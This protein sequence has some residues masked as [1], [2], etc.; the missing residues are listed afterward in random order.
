MQ[1]NRMW[2]P[3]LTRRCTGTSEESA[4]STPP[5]LLTRKDCSRAETAVYLAACRSLLDCKTES[6][7][8]ASAHVPSTKYDLYKTVLNFTYL[9]NCLMQ[10]RQSTVGTES[11]AIQHCILGTVICTLAGLCAYLRASNTCGGIINAA[12]GTHGLGYICVMVQSNA[13]PSIPASI[14]CRMSIPAN[15]S[16]DIRGSQ[17]R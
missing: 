6:D 17:L 1:A 13:C 16:A 11:L 7:L 10:C 3:N 15:D 8:S 4:K 12:A 14:V 2:N 5:F 9:A